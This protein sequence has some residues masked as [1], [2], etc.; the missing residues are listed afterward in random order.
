VEYGAAG[1][2]TEKEDP[3]VINPMGVADSAGK[4]RLICNMKYVNLFLEALPFKYERLRDLLA[5]TKR[6]S[7]LAT[8]DWK[9][10]YFHVPIH[11]EFCKY[12]C[13]RIGG[14]TFYF[15][16]LCFG[17]TQACFVFTKVMQE[18]VFELWKRGIPNS[19]Y[20]DDAL[21]AARTFHRC[22]RQ[23]ALS[24]IFMEALGA[25]LGLPKCKLT[26][27]QI[28]KWLGFL[29]N[30]CEESFEVGESKIEKIKAVLIEMVRKPNTSPRAL[31]RVAG[32]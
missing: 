17:F 28:L 32:R 21:T 13:F 24:A 31:A 16:V 30:T 4:D 27:E 6:G 20:I 19:S 5:F 12:F 3:V 29:I 7:Y 25:Y 18:P 10:G 26:L 23:S 22:A 8:W 15:K 14:V 2:W 1:I 11:P 9:S